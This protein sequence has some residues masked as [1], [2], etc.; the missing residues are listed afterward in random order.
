MTARATGRCL[1]GAVTYR[2]DGPLRDVVNC[3]CH[4]CRRHTGHFMAATQAAAD[5]LEVDDDGAVRWYEPG[6]R[7]RYGFCGTCGSTLFWKSDT[8]PDAV[9]IAAGTLDPPTGLSTTQ[10]LFVAAASDYHRPDPSL[11]NYPGDR[12]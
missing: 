12:P 6:D 5:H 10:A 11:D 2:V 1:C 7:V 8:R 4:R 3:H 9:S